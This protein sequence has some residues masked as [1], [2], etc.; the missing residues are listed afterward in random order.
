[1]GSRVDFW[2]FYCFLSP[3]A[4]LD[5]FEDEFQTTVGVPPPSGLET[6]WLFDNTPRVSGTPGPCGARIAAQVDLVSLRPA[7]NAADTYK[8]CGL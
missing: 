3:E 7:R 2:D 5:H 1:M 4:L 8:D 6:I